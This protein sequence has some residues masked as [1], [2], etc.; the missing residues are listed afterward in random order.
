M[1][2]GITVGNGFGGLLRFRGGGSPATED[3]RR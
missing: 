1:K 3:A 2:R